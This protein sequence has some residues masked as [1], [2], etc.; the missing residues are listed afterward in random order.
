MSMQW[1]LYK[2]SRDVLVKG[3]DLFKKTNSSAAA[4]SSCSANAHF[5]K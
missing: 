1:I 5:S 4:G 3:T 2:I